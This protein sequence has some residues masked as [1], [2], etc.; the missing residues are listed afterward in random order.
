MAKITRCFNYV[1]SIFIGVPNCL[2]DSIFFAKKCGFAKEAIFYQTAISAVNLKLPVT[3][4]LYL[5]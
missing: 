3:T 4:C 1:I 2:E 5:F